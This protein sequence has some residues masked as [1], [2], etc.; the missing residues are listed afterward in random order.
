MYMTITKINIAIV[1]ID[2]KYIFFL[3]HMQPVETS[4]FVKCI[5][6]HCVRHQYTT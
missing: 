4:L 6:A 3:K 2:T 1:K 5:G